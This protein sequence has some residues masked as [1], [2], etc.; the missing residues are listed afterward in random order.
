MVTEIISRVDEEVANGRAWHAKEILR[1]TLATRAEPALLERYGRLLEELRDRYEAGRYLFLSG[2]RRPE[3]AESIAL[4]LARHA[5]RRDADLVQQFPV[6]VRRL[7]FEQLPAVVQEELRQRGVRES[8]FSG[9]SPILPPDP[10]WKRWP[11]M[12]GAWL[13]FAL[14]MSSLV[15]GFVQIMKWLVGLGR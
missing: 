10:W 11:S 12:I 15:V 6:A 14:F 5:S 1:G 8:R 3:Y 13:F 7:P 2:A 9:A 4:F